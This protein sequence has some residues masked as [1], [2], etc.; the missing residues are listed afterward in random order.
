LVIIVALLLSVGGLALFGALLTYGEKGEAFIS[1]AA[2]SIFTLTPGLI[3]LPILIYHIV[4][5]RPASKPQT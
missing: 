5:S 3:M 4:T 1:F 2:I